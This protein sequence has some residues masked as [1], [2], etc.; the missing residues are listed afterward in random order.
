VRQ[1]LDEDRVM[2]DIA[3]LPAVLLWVLQTQVADRG[4]LGE[5]VVGKPAVLLPPVGVRCELRRD[6][7]AVKGG[8]S[9]RVAGAEGMPFM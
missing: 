7:A 3:A 9:C 5:D 8:S 2:Q 1:L 4:E 6:E